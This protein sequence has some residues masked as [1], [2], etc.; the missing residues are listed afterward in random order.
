M[1]GPRASLAE[2]KADPVSLYIGLNNRGDSANGTIYLDDG[3][4][5]AY[6]KGEFAFWGSLS[7]KK[8]MIISSQLPARIWTKKGNLES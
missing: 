7:R 5:F 4:T 6:E 1:D 3:E 8:L 2:T